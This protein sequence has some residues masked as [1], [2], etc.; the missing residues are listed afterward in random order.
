MLASSNT[1]ERLDDLRTAGARVGT[2]TVVGEPRAVREELTDEGAVK[3]YASRLVVAVPGGPERLVVRGAHT[4]ERPRPGTEVDVLWAAAEP[5]LGGYVNESKDLES[6]ARGRR[7]AAHCSPS[8]PSWWCAARSGPGLHVLAP[9]GRPSAAG[10][11]GPTRTAR[12]VSA[13]LAF[14]A[15][16]PLVLGHGPDPAQVLLAGG[17]FL[18][19]P[20]TYVAASVRSFR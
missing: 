9:G 6:L 12:A 7:A 8:P 16:G 4:Y 18:L 17:G 13:L 10:R 2:A 15:G 1:G 20:L 3:G 19:V 11:V 14:G 5:E